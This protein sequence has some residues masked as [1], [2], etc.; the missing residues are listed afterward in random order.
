[1]T[2]S[3]LQPDEPCAPRN[4]HGNAR[5]WRV[6]VV[7]PCKSSWRAP[8][9]EARSEQGQTPPA[10]G[11][12]T[13]HDMSGEAG[14][15]AHTSAQ[16]RLALPASLKCDWQH[17]WLQ[18][19]TPKPQSRARFGGP[20]PHPACLRLCTRF[21]SRLRHTRGD[22]HAPRGRPSLSAGHAW[23]T[24]SRRAPVRERPSL[25]RFTQ[26]YR[27]RTSMWRPCASASSR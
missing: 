7:L 15:Q 8:E 18:P 27:W 11:P 25:Q 24:E 2:G 23:P 26:C 16:Q 6:P 4:T 20:K 22:L 9:G 5:R 12:T 19:A 21:A 13:T 17:W 3:H 10:C 14:G 1:M